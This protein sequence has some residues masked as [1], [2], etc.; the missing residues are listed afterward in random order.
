MWADGRTGVAALRP[1]IDGAKRE[2]MFGNGHYEKGAHSV[3]N[4]TH[5]AT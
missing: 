5:I 1:P 4:P 3:V 2:R